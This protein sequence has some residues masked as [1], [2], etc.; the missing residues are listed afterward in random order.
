MF[1]RLAIFLTTLFLTLQIKAQISEGGFPPSFAYDNSPGSEIPVTDIPVIFNVDDLTTVDEWQVSNGY[2]LK[3]A[4]SIPV[5]LNTRNSG[6][7]LTLPGGEHIWQLRI[8]AK[9]AIGLML[10]YKTFQL[11]EGGELYLYNADKTQVLGAYTHRTNPRGDR[12]ATEFVAGDDLILEYINSSSE[13]DPRIEIEE[14]GY[15]YN[16][17]YMLENTPKSSGVCM[18]N[19]NCEEGEAWQKESSGV[20]H[21]VQKIG[22]STYICSGSLVNNTAEDFKP[23]VLMACHCMTALSND[24]GI[25]QA[26]SPEDMKQWMFYFNLESTGCAY[27]APADYKTMTGCRKVASSPMNGGSDGLLVELDQYVPESYNVYYNGWD[28]RD[29]APESGVG[30]HHPKGDYKKVS[31]YSDK[32]N[33]TSW[34]GENHDRGIKNGHWNVR[35]VRTANG[36]GVIE[37]GSSGSPLFNQDHLI[38]GTLSGGTSSCDEPDGLNLYGKLAYHWDKYGSEDSSQMDIWLDPLK[39]G[40]ETLGGISRTKVMPT[41]T[42]LKIRIVNNAAILTWNSPFYTQTVSR[43]ESAPMSIRPNAHTTPLF[44]L[45]VGYNVYRDENLLAT[46][47][48]SNLFYI[49]RSIPYYTYSTLNTY[50]YA[51]SAVYADGESD[52]AELS[53]SSVGYQEIL[54]EAVN[55]TPAV[56]SD[57]VQINN[58]HKVEKIE[59]YAISGHLVMRQTGPDERIDTSFLLPG[60]YIFKLYTGEGI[61]TIQTIKK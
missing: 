10:Y 18:V 9:G 41:P 15:G 36:H 17:L 50:I 5:S 1:I 23:Y 48:P 11:P 13:D 55:I 46:T 6:Q 42:N 22:K 43:T 37:G 29:T 57:W 21:T 26:S 31:T 44:P 47:P 54:T 58:P 20:C 59:V 4:T 56:F 25:P 7:W 32:A 49:D 39:T 61:K 14:V 60:V 53:T 12:F 40:A 27:T 2:P 30:I 34:Y 45:L 52:K 24:P 19:V 35:F 16:H 8:R 3:V 33:Q 38:V 51:V 28:R